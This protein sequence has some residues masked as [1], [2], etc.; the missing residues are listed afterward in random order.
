MT[1]DGHAVLL[2]VPSQQSHGSSQTAE[3]L[4]WPGTTV[5]CLPVCLPKWNFCTWTHVVA[6][7][8]GQL[9]KFYMWYMNYTEGR[10]R[11]GRQ[12]GGKRKDEDEIKKLK[13]YFSFFFFRYR[14][15]LKPV[16]C[17]ILIL[18]TSAS[19]LTAV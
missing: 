2:F 3:A 18:A 14:S 8:D 4:L 9:L 15:F 7:S 16:T 6:H 19:P 10:C 12:L 11:R 17:I 13:M 5:C 1:D